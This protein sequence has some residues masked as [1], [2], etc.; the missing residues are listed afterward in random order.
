MENT[1][2]IGLLAACSYCSLLGR[3]HR[4]PLAVQTAIGSR[5]AQSC[6]DF[7]A[8]ERE[9][10]ITDME[11]GERI[12]ASPAWRERDE[13]LQNVPGVGPVPSRPL[14]TDLPELG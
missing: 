12:E 10:R 9:L 13:L 7:R 1:G 2:A 11:L 5:C 3:E 14:L 6:F 4:P 8:A